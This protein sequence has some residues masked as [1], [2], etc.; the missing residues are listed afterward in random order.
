MMTIRW[1]A[2]GQHVLFEAAAGPRPAGKAAKARNP[3]EKVNTEKIT[4]TNRC[5][6]YS[7]AQKIPIRNDPDRKYSYLD[8]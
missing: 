1:R 2:T 4:A 3:Q 6:N 7:P 5:M 8:E